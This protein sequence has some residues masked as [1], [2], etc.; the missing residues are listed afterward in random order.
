MRVFVTGA[1]GHIGSTVVP[2]LLG[3]GHE[4][5]G[6][7]RSEASAAALTAAGAKVQLGDLDD[8]A[9]LRDAAAAADGVIHLAFKH[10]AMFRG[11]VAGALEANRLAIETIG[12]ALEGSGKPFLIASGTL[13]LAFAGL[14]HPGTEADVLETGLRVDAENYVV[15]L[16]ER[17]V[18]SSVLRLP[19]T[20][21]SS[22]DHQGFIP[23]MIGFARDKGVS[24][25]VGDGSNRWSAGH[26]LDVAHLYRLALESAPPDRGCT[27]SAMRASRSARSPRR[28]AASLT[29]R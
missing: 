25:Y 24:P 29:C 10:D 17:G 11:D 3:A 16:A 8:L 19:P 12:A 1:S 23:A 21:H 5:T 20:V 26:T 15:A 9:T 14:D 18:R 7:A 2:E 4:V 27:P 22:L 6:L 28:S 13:M